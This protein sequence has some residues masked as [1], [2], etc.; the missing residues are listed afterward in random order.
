METAPVQ[1]SALRRDKKQMQSKDEE[2]HFIQNDPAKYRSQKGKSDV[3][4]KG[5]H[6]P[7]AYIKL[8]PKMLNKRNLKK[9]V[10]TFDLVID[11]K[12]AGKRVKEG[13]RKMIL[14]LIYLI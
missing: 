10:K 13:M 1:S 5:E 14:K 12:K 3:V 11:K 6:D 8:N 4:K 9:A 2:G 7:F